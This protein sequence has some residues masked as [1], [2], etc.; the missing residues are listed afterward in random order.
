[1]SPLSGI[2]KPLTIFDVYIFFLQWKAG[3]PLPSLSISILGM[4]DLETMCC[5]IMS[6]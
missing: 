5:L 6:E 3:L 1:M 2:F 4:I